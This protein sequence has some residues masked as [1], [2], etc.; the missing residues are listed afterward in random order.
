MSHLA[1]F[2]LK[3]D[4]L[5]HWPALENPL[6]SNQAK[7]QRNQIKSGVTKFQLQCG[8]PIKIDQQN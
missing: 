5:T 8:Q 2:H 6:K 4:C 3:L 1:W 7:L